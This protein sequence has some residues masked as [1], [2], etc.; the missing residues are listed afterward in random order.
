MSEFAAAVAAIDPERLFTATPTELLTDLG[1]N[2]LKGPER[3]R[4]VSHIGVAQ[5]RLAM[6]AARTMRTTPCLHCDGEGTQDCDDCAGG[7]CSTCDDENG[8]VACDDCDGAGVDAVTARTL[9]AEQLAETAGRIASEMMDKLLIA[10]ALVGGQGGDTLEQRLQ[11]A[12]A[13][14]GA[15]SGETLT[16]ACSRA[17]AERDDLAVQVEHLGDALEAAEADVDRLERESSAL[18]AE[19]LRARRPW[20]R[21]LADWWAL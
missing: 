9:E 10:E 2:H 18:E 19:L 11:Y 1:L 3:R 21:R 15:V 8:Q 12:L 13:V 5:A 14:G 16:N 17:S 6:Q 20:W 7:G 4:T